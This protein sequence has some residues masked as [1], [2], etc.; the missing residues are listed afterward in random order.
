MTSK[1]SLFIGCWELTHI[2]QMAGKHSTHYF[3]RCQANIMTTIYLILENKMKKIEEHLKL[4]D[5]A[6]KLIIIS[7]C[8]DGGPR[9]RVC[10][11]LGHC[12][13]TKCPL[14]LVLFLSE[15]SV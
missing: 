12:C 7:A 4:P 3:C 11:A 13:G 6:R 10:T 1:A 15:W 5:F 2:M 9:F 14:Y 8:A